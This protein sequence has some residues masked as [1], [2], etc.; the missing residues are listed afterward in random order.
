MFRLVI[1][2]QEVKIKLR[3]STI[4]RQVVIKPFHL[5]KYDNP[6]YAEVRNDCIVTS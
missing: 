2:L 3:C 6:A 1:L 5:H 4:K